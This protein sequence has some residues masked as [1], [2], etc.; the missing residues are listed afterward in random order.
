PRLRREHHR[1]PTRHRGHGGPHEAEP[2][3]A[4]ARRTTHD[5]RRL[6]PPE[7]RDR[8]QAMNEKP[9]HTDDALDGLLAHFFNAQFQKHWPAAPVVVA[10]ATPA[11]PRNESPAHDSGN[12]ARYTL[13]ASVAL[14]LGTCWT[15][16]NGFQA[17]ERPAGPSPAPSA[18]GMNMNSL[19]ASNPDAL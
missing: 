4:A 19:G 15:L 7:Q 13:A 17:G 6:R 5:P 1:R 14:L 12:R 2:G 10:S 3:T 9:T 11:A 18:P 8:P 16:S